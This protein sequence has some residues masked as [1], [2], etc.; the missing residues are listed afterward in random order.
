VRT[1][2]RELDRTTH[3]LIV[4]GA[5]IQGAAMARDAAERGIS[6]VLVDSRDVAAGTSSRSSRLV[7]GGLRYLK[8]GHIG[9]VR[10]ALLERERLLRS[11]P[12]LVRPLPMVMPFFRDGGGSPAMMRLGT[13]L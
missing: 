4:V 5:G 12:H 9:L 8:Q 3:E 7:H 11:C 6:V 13:M 1:D 10:E 2:P